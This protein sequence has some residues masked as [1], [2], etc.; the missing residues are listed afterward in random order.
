[1]ADPQTD[2]PIMPAIAEQIHLNPQG[3]YETARKYT[4]TH[5]QSK[6]PS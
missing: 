4:K 2:S 6:S 1:M 3:F 5:A